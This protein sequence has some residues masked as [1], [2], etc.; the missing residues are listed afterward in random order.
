MTFELKGLNKQGGI[1][2]NALQRKAAKKQVPLLDEV[3]KMIEFRVKYREWKEKYPLCTKK[4]LSSVS[5]VL[6]CEKKKQVVLQH[7]DGDIKQW[8]FDG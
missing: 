3:Y 1:L 4:G 5:Q 7:H 8:T 6:S 2:Y